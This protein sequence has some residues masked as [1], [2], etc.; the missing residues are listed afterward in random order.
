M[1]G[2]YLKT[3]LKMNFKKDFKKDKIIRTAFAEWGKFFF[4]NTSLSVIIKKLRITK[5]AL[6]RYFKNK[7]ELI[8]SMKLKILDK[9][10]ERIDSF[11]IE[12][13]EDYSIDS[14]YLFI[15]K[16]FGYFF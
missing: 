3:D 13:T 9:F 11:I 5:P 16:I 2:I 15:N 14:V 10:Y 6:Y 1:T 7:K 4:R 8:N 12:S